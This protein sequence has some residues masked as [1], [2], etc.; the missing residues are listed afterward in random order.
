MI[1]VTQHVVTQNLTKL[2]IQII[3]AKFNRLPINH[4]HVQVYLQL[5]HSLRD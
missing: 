4:M 1:R 5:C 3:A 2:C